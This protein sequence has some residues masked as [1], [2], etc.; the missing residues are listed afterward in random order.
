[1]LRWFLLADDKVQKQ[2]G[3]DDDTENMTAE[4]GPGTKHLG[5]IRTVGNSG[6]GLGVRKMN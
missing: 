6:V 4:T 3:K 2:S 5:G 1:M